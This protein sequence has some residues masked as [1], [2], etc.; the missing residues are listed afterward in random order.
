M[1]FP[2]TILL[3]TF[4]L[5]RSQS[6]STSSRAC[7]P[8]T[9]N[10]LNIRNPFW[11]PGLQ[12]SHC[13]R[14][15]F[16]ITCHDNKPVIKINGDGFIVRDIFYKNASFL[17]ANLNVFDAGIQCPTPRRNFTVDGTPFSYGPATSDLFFFYDCTS[18]YDRETYAVDCASNAS[19]HS[20]AVFHVELL[21][22]WNYSIESCQ[23]PV[24]APVED[25]GLDKLLQMNYTTILK[26]GFVLQWERRNCS[27]CAGSGLNL[28]LK[29]GIGVGAAAV[30]ASAMCIIFLVYHRR[31]RKRYVSSSLVSRGSSS[32]PSLTK[33][34]EKAGVH[35]FDYNELEEATNHFDPKMELGDGGYGAVYKAKLRDGRVVAVKRLY[36]NHCRRVE[37]FLNEVE[38][39][40]RLRHQNL[41]S[42]Y[43]CTSR[44]CG[45][46][47]LVYEYIPNGTL[48]DHLHGS[49]ASPGSLSWMTRLNIA[50]EIASALAYL[51]ASGV[52]HRDVKSTNILLDDNFIVKVADFGLSRLIPMDVTH[53][54]TAPQGTPGYVDPEYGEF[55]QLTGKSDVYSFGVVLI[56]LISSKPA[57]DLTRHRNEI[58][59]S[60]MAINKIQNK[61]LHEL[62]DPHVG[63]DSDYKV[64]TMIVAVAEL[65]FQCLQNTKDMRPNMHDVLSVLQEIKS[66]DYSKDVMDILLLK[67]NSLP[68]LK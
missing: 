24:N 4:F 11:I 29:I 7:P 1:A 14:L 49:R 58:N 10:G 15:G 53:V 26:K 55:Y 37:Q 41:V 63:F 60:T 68:K 23:P 42:L 52:I 5:K 32:Y 48:A 30:G 12:H 8:Q 33:D 51:H 47:I 40:A 20:F 36:D 34:L 21:E 25:D 62:V 27:S 6:Y 38:L 16:N 43:G 59:L 39:L 45:E 54:S 19:H 56:E 3:F 9:C 2:I 66:K 35:I 64:R 17:L 44:D 31:Y 67:S 61:A 50:V 57:V 13:G 22:H 65:A 46:L 28:G 18:S